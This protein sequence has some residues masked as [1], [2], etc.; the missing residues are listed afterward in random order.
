MTSMQIKF[1][2]NY[3]WINLIHK[4]ISGKK[5]LIIPSQFSTF[6]SKK[7]KKFNSFYFLFHQYIPVPPLNV[8]ISNC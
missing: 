2:P 1:D 8:Q 4:I 7:K 5:M 6:P 3:K